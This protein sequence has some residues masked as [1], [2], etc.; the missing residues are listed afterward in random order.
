MP[1]QNREPL[2]EQSANA[3]QNVTTGP[4]STSTVSF[5]SFMTLCIPAK[6]IIHRVVV[7]FT[8]SHGAMTKTTSSQK[9]AIKCVASC[10]T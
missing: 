8:R 1:T 3:V 6:F 9:A 7:Y 4:S 10:V 5:H 2:A